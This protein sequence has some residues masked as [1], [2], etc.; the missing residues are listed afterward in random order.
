MSISHNTA[1]S[2]KKILS[3]ATTFQ[4]LILTADPG[5][6][7][8]DSVTW[9]WLSAHRLQRSNWFVCLAGAAAAA[10]PTTDGGHRDSLTSVTTNFGGITS[11]WTVSVLLQALT[12]ESRASSPMASPVAD[13]GQSHQH[14]PE[15]E[16]AADSAFHEAQKWIEVSPWASVLSPDTVWSSQYFPF[17][18]V[19]V[20][21]VWP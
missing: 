9:Q 8:T 3:S 19:F 10:T 20:V 18:Q 6:S 4:A 15:S 5:S 12:L 17:P 7:L 16:S 21:V 2:K 11:D 14:H 13:I 1:V